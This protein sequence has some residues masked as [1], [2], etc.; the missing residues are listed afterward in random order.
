MCAAITRLD[1]TEIYRNPWMTLKEDRVRRADGSEGIYAL[2]EK[3]DFVVIL[4]VE[5][6][7]IYLVEQYRY[8]LGKTTLE[9]PQGS[10]EHRPDAAPDTVAAG[11]LREETGLE[12]ATLTRVGYQKLAQG[13][14]AQGYHIY[15]ATDLQYRGQQLDAEEYGL[16]AR[17]MPVDTFL[18]LI[19]AGE[20][21]DATS[22][23]AFLLARARGLI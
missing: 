13:Y 17:K 3:P 8:P 1:S 16:T 14:S 11:E 15:L 12:A 9:L 2:V 4:P 23:A 7:Q 19:L 22:V 20:I 5:D 6:G 10:W 18:G 21:S